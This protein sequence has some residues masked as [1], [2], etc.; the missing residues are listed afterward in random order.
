MASF[1]LGLPTY[2]RVDRNASYA[3]QSTVYSAYIQDSWQIRLRLT[4]SLGLRYDRGPLT[5]RFNRTVRGYD[6]VSTSPLAREVQAKYAANPISE[7][8]AG[9]F[10]LIGGLTFPGVGGQPRTL[11]NRAQ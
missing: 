4:L 6:F 1:L 10:R 9:Q 7:I 5:E 8:P 11:W 3:E 2:G